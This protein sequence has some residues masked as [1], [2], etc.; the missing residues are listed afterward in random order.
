MPARGRF[1][2]LSVLALVA[3]AAALARDP[4]PAAPS[5]AAAIDRIV[6]RPAFAPAFWGIEVRDL[7]SG[8]VLYS[9]NASKNLTP[10]STMKLV[11]T[12]AA[13]DA[14]GP[15]ARLRTT[16]ESAGAPDASGRLA[17]DLYLVGR[18]D[19]G[20][21]EREADGRT[22]FD[23]FADTLWAAGVR[24]VDGRVVGHEGLFKGDRRGASWEWDD[25]VWC[26]GAEVSA[27]SW[28]T[29]C[30][31]VVL[32]PGARQGD[33]AVI[34]RDPSSSYYDVQS[35]VVT[36]AAGQKSDL[37]LVRDL[38]SSVIRLSGSY[39]VG[40]E[41]DVLEVALEDPARYAATVFAERLTS[42]GIRVGGAVATSS[43]ALPPGLRVLASHDSEPLSEILKTTNKPSNNFKAESLLRL[44]GLQAKGEGSTSAGLEAIADFLKRSGVDIATAAIGDGSGMAPTDL[45]APHQVV[46]LLVAMD[47]HRY[48]QAF[49]DSLPVAGVD[50]T[51]EHRMRGTRAERRV[52]AKTGTRRHANALAGYVTTLSGR[53][54]VFSMAVGNHTSPSREA[55]A[56]IDAICNV[57]VGV[58]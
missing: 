8:H 7:R 48:A 29:S 11:T 55:T 49:R 33:A 26:Y 13:L 57:L 1:L 2:V 31:N 50:G 38:G 52:V 19:P 30:A 22:A 58:P 34:S 54:L 35:T 27:L 46:D 12:A 24:T 15:E 45:L 51:L 28:N 23:V 9:R 42:R 53:R 3:P 44:V 18:G 16:V 5:F 32:S 56:A 14:L 17:G 4:R 47:A 36:A 39:P 25:L 41:A 6:E 40:A 21:A 43:D 37:T 20:L 10:A